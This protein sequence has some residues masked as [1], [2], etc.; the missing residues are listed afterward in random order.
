MHKTVVAVVLA[1][2]CWS[3]SQECQTFYREASDSA[4][5]TARLGRGYEATLAVGSGE[6]PLVV[7]GTVPP[8]MAVEVSNGKIRVTGTP[9]ENGTF[10]ADIR[11]TKTACEFEDASFV[12][13]VLDIT[14]ADAECDSPLACRLLKRGACN[15]SSAC[16]PTAPYTSAACIPTVGVAGACVDVNGPADQCSGSVSAQSL[17]TIEGAQV[18]SCV[19]TPALVGCNYHLCSGPP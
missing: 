19:A 7:T 16:V 11:P 13:I 1:L 17:T 15:Q 2:T 18:D 3:C 12:N 8:G 10:K 9:T 6:E 5:Q 4:G 14:V